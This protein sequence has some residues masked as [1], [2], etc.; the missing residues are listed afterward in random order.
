MPAEAIHLSAL[1][2]TRSAAD[3]AIERLLRV[4]ERPARLGAVLV[5]LPYFERFPVELLRY[6]THQQPRP[7]RRGCLWM[8]IG[9]S[10]TAGQWRRFHSA[11]STST[12][13]R[14][15]MP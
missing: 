6:V 15:S 12:T 7:S 8:D 13:A 14:C 5:D 11:G 10:E 3:A 2:D 4:H 9:F 1:G